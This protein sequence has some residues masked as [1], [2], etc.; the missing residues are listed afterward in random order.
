[1]PLIIAGYGAPR[2]GP[3]I[4]PVQAREGKALADP[5]DRR[6]LD[7]AGNRRSCTGHFLFFGHFHVDPTGEIGKNIIVE[8]LRAAAETPGAFLFGGK[9]RA[10]DHIGLAKA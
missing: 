1:M 2:T 9:C 10:Q 3:C 6:G 5:G 8:E 4:G 7:S